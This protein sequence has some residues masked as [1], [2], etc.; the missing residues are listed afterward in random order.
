[1]TVIGRWERFCNWLEAKPWRWRYDRIWR[2]IQ[3]DP[4]FLRRLWWTVTFPH[5][6]HDD[7]GAVVC[8]DALAKLVRAEYPSTYSLAQIA[9][10]WGEGLTDDERAALRAWGQ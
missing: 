7:E 5:V 3:G 10:T 1:M 6:H 4:P 8:R 9:E 2:G